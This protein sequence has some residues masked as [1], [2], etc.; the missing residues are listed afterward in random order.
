MPPSRKINLREIREDIPDLRIEDITPKTAKLLLD[1]AREDTKLGGKFRNTNKRTVGRYA[2]EMKAGRWSPVAG[3]PLQVDQNGILRNGFHRLEAVIESGRESVPMAVAW[4]TNVL[5]ELATDTGRNRSLADV[6]GAAV[7]AATYRPLAASASVMAYLYE[8][9]DYDLR[10]TVNMV[11][12]D[13]TKA[14]VASIYGDQLP[15]SLKPTHTEAVEYLHT[16][17]GRALLES[18]AYVGPFQ[19]EL[20]FS[21]HLLA[22]LHHA[23]SQR[24]PERLIECEMF[25]EQLAKGEMI[26]QKTYAYQIRRWCFANIDLKNTARYRKAVFSMVIE[27]W[28][29][30]CNGVPSKRLKTWNI[31]RDSAKLP[32]DLIGQFDHDEEYQNELLAKKSPATRKKKPVGRRKTRRKAG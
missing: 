27:A 7:P 6:I 20:P 24:D 31:K 4:G 15:S 25:I 13:G 29:S 28:N 1:K 23:V 5:D 19:P 21:P 2:R 17:S 32:R 26:E 3:S 8:L 12:F 14:S 10:A 9:T 11:G 22:F 30:L 18:V 16:P